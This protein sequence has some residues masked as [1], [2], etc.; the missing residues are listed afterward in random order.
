MNNLQQPLPTHL[1]GSAIRQSFLD[2]FSNKQHTILSSAPLLP[3]SPNLLFTNAGMNPFVPIFLGQQKPDV[4]TWPGAQPASPR[5]AANSQ[6]C[7]RAGGKHNDLEDVGLDTYHHTLFEMLGNW[8]FGDYFKPEALAWAWELLTEVWKFPPQRLYATIYQPSPGD[9]A[10]TDEEAREIWRGIFRS[11]GLD[12]DTHV[13]TGGKKDN[14]WMM[15]E[16]G[17][18]GPCSEIHV[19]LT[20]DADTRGRLVNASSPLCIEIWN[21]VFIQYNALPD[22][23]IEP[24]PARHVDTGMGL[25][26][27]TAILQATRGFTTFP[28]ANRLISN[29]DTDLFQP[30]FASLGTLCGK[31]YT[32]TLPQPGCQI[33]NLPR[34]VRDDIAFRVI[35]DHLRALSF[36][37]ADGITPSNEGRG[38][39][40]RRIL[41]R[42]VR[43]GRDLGLHRPFLNELFDTLRQN[44]SAHFPQL[45]KNSTLVRDT[46]LSEEQSFLRTLEKGLALF[47]AEVEKISTN[48]SSS[49]ILPGDA[50]FLLADTYGFPLDLTQLLARERGLSVDTARFEALME[51]QRNRARAAR[52]TTTIE[53]THVPDVPPTEF[54][55]YQDLSCPARVLWKKDSLIALDISPFY[56]E[57]GGQVSD[58]GHIIYNGHA[59]G[60]IAV[61]RT[62]EGVILHALENTDLIAGA[63]VIAEVNTVTRQRTA[64]HHTLTHL[65]HWALRELLGPTVTQK[66]SYVGPDRLRFDFAHPSA[67]T[68]KQLDSLQKMLEQRVAAS[69]TVSWLDGVPYAEVRNRSDIMQFFTDKYGDTVRVVQIGGRPAELDGYSMELCAGTHLYDH[70][71]HR[72]VTTREI[73]HVK[74]LSESAIAA[75]VRRIE[76]VAGSASAEEAQNRLNALQIRLSDAKNKLQGLAS[77]KVP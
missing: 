26:R 10:T 33:A 8:S 23:N 1:S 29:Y 57:M 42:A 41:R 32:A 16:T 74:I 11:A 9:P 17:P 30:L 77:A 25:E 7:I 58:V 19:D 12:P 53:V 54:I 61:K 21:N 27:V 65:L 73:G 67:L 69:D 40:L 2:F 70:E 49:K 44:Y 5:R 62:A 60:V 52:R 68:D 46:L 37:I 72:W 6:L 24:L 22:G 56:A 50:A 55:G 34:H 66:G 4:H 75:G 39:V 18:C 47:D 38:Y 48:P 31:N 36:A 20:P 28:Q 51:Q 43:F 14:F 45:E 71:H 3:T 64:A 63:S 35:A 15:G 76:A 13:L 59:I